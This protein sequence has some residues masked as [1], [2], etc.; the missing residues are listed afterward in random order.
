MKFMRR[1]AKYTW[2]DY[3]AMKLFCQNL[4]LTQLQRKFKI[5]ETN[6][7]NI[8]GEWKETD[9]H[10]YEISTMW[11]TKPWTTPQ[12]TSKLLMGPEKVTRSKTLEP[13]W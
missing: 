2:Q 4:K 3:R 12:M 6:G 1:R 8:F 7:Y 5:T 11:E 13:I 9:C 10:N